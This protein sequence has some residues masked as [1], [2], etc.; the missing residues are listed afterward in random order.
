MCGSIPC[1][2]LSVHGYFRQQVYLQPVCIY[3]IVVRVQFRYLTYL[4]TYSAAVYISEHESKIRCENLTRIGKLTE[5]H[6]VITGVSVSAA[7]IIALS[8]CWPH[9]AY[10]FVSDAVFC[11]VVTTNKT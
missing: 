8:S 10:K 6:S 9:L 11:D 7:I 3:V 4:F 5:A 1:S 2:L